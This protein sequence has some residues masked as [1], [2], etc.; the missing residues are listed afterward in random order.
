[1]GEYVMGRCEKTEPRGP[2]ASPEN[3]LKKK[4]KKDSGGEEEFFEKREREDTAPILALSE[5][6]RTPIRDLFRGRQKKRGK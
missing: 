5:R 3:L 6:K 1:M 4:K 2:S